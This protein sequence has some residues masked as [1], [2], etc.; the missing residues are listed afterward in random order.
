MAVR[1]LMQYLYHLDY[2]YIALSGQVTDVDKPVI[3]P[4]GATELYE[5]VDVP[6]ASAGEGLTQ[7]TMN[8]QLDASSGPEVKVEGKEPSAQIPSFFVVGETNLIIHVK[9]YALAE[10]YVIGGLK[11]VAFM[12]FKAELETSWNTQD[13]LEAVEFVYDYTMVWDRGMRDTIVQVFHDNKV[14]DGEGVMDYL[15]GNTD[16][17]FDLFM[18]THTLNRR[19]TR[20]AESSSL[21]KGRR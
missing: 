10:K 5:V 3:L 8:H 13:F 12:K 19:L 6:T 16:L 1:L 15:K 7:P 18:Y 21:K 14:I 20:A 11:D 17:I 2:P 9:V 4:A